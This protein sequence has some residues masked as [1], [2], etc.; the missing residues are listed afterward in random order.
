MATLIDYVNH[1]LEELKTTFESIQKRYLDPYR[2]R[3][4][5]ATN[6]YV[7]V[8]KD[9]NKMVSLLYGDNV[10][11]EGLKVTNISYASDYVDITVE[12]GSAICDKTIIEFTDDMILRVPKSWLNTD[13][14]NYN[15][16][17]IDY[18]HAETYPPRV[19]YLVVFEYQTTVPYQVTTIVNVFK[20]SMFSAIVFFSLY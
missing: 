4:T 15:I 3:L 1:S 12:K 19:A 5:T 9:I 8:G 7:F 11:L 13:N 2:I 14:S 17:A 20:T 18:N 16:V 10:I 6:E